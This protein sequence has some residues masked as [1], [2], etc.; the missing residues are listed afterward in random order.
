MIVK[1]LFQKLIQIYFNMKVLWKLMINFGLI[2]FIV[3]LIA[4]ISQTGIHQFHHKL[5]SVINE[6][7]EPLVYLH[8]IR[9]CVSDME[10]TVKDAILQKD[11]VALQ[12][13]NNKYL[14]NTVRKTV[15]YSFQKLL[16]NAPDKKIKRNLREIRQYWLQYY[17]LYQQLPGEQSLSQ[18][19]EFTL[20]ANQLRYFLIGGIDRLIENHYRQQAVLAKTEAANIYQN[21]QFSTWILLSAAIL[22]TLLISILT[23][24][25]MVTPLQKMAIAS[26]QI[27]SGDLKVNLPV[28]RRD[29]FGEV[30]SCFNMMTAELTLLVEKVKHAADRVNENSQKLLEGTGVSSAA[31]RQLMNTIA[32]VAEGAT[33]QQQKVTSVREIVQTISEFS[34]HVNEITRQVSDLAEDTVVKALHGEKTIDQVVHKIQVIREFMNQSDGIMKRLQSLSGDIGKMTLVIEDIAEQTNLLSLNAAIEAARAGKLG[35]GFGVV[36][37]SI[38]QLAEQTREAAGQTRDLV[39]QIQTMFVNLVTMIQSENTII[40]EN[41]QATQ[42]LES[43]FDNIIVAAKQVDSSIDEVSKQ[44][45]HLAHE[46]GIMLSAMGEIT[47]IAD[48]HKKGTIQAS[49]A[50]GEH[51]SCT[52]EIIDASHR[53][54]HWGKNLRQAVDKFKIKNFAE[55]PKNHPPKN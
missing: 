42:G 26:R 54:A 53:L 6:E 51:F 29:E 24:W 9:S 23:T 34:R 46:H 19:S 25:M 10:I 8:D 5:I 3:F 55:I 16:E 14:P 32:Q 28:N 44:V 48:Q 1:T 36:A 22:F 39:S 40:Q 41:E 13:I 17:K 2:L 38:G 11:T 31:T 37:D 52:Q 20:K 30:S 45:F 7:L 15:D 35:K 4:G 47:N 21:Q 27:A 49:A 18:S 33:I 50:A 12:Y 43:V